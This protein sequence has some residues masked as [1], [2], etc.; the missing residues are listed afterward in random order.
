MMDLM[1][2]RL[3]AREQGNRAKRH[4]KEPYIVWPEDL[5]DWTLALAAGRLPRLPLPNIGTYVPA[6][7]KLTGR[8]WFC[9]KFGDGDNGPSTSARELVE[10]LEVGKAYA[11][12]EEGEFQL[13]VSEFE[14]PAR[15]PK[16]GG[17]LT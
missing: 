9:D 13:Y 10:A 8:E 1:T 6:G 4:G 16:N 2:I 15:R 14:P 5:A 11:I 12:T 7:W 3:L 17:T